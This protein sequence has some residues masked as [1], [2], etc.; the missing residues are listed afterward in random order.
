MS[1]PGLF[2]L[3]GNAPIPSPSRALCAPRVPPMAGGAP[4]RRAGGGWEDAF[5]AKR[6]GVSCDV[7]PRF[8][9][10]S[11]SRRPSTGNPVVAAF[12]FPA[13][14][15]VTR[16]VTVLE[17]QAASI[18]AV[19]LQRQALSLSRFAYLSEIGASEFV[20]AAA[21]IEHAAFLL[22]LVAHS[23]REAARERREALRLRA[24]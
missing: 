20:D 2:L 17:M 23:V 13:G 7:P 21:K 14:E 24:A 16:S 9:P 5:P 8:Q 11:R 10:G 19:K 6:A 1:A 22:R 18:E 4:A 3:R 12:K 15:T